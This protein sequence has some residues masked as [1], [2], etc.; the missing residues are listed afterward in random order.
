MTYILCIVLVRSLHTIVLTCT[1]TLSSWRLELTYTSYMYVDIFPEDRTYSYIHYKY[2][3]LHR[4][5]KLTHIIWVPHKLVYAYGHVLAFVQ[6]AV[7]VK[8]IYYWVSVFLGVFNLLVFYATLRGRTRTPATSLNH[9]IIF[10][11][12]EKCVFV[13]TLPPCMA[14]A[15]L[16]LSLFENPILK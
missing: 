3:H 10:E 11:M 8:S 4:A 13:F 7:T 16:N 6:K 12:F 9:S 5:Y 2:W 15:R 14:W 1:Y